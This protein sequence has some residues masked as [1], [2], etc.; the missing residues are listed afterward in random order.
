MF[1]QNQRPVK[2][3]PTSIATLEAAYEI[4]RKHGLRYV[5]IGNVPGHIRNSTFCPSCNQ[6]VIYR[7]HFDVLEINLMNGKC[8]FCQY[9]IEGKWA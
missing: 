7:T 1:T 9:T 5:Y 6:R 3:A 8:K 4:A 2:L